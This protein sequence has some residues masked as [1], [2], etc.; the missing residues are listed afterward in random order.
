[1]P[2]QNAT[3]PRE[4]PAADPLSPVSPDDA[5][6]EWSRIAQQDLSAENGF[7]RE[8]KLRAYEF[9]FLPRE[10]HNF[11]LTEANSDRIASERDWLYARTRDDVWARRLADRASARAL[12]GA[13]AGHLEPMHYH[14]LVRAGRL[15]CVPTSEEAHAAGAGLGGMHAFL[16]SHGP[17]TVAGSDW[18]CAP[19]ARLQ[20]ADGPEARFALDGLPLSDEQLEGWLEPAAQ[21]HELAL[22]DPPAFGNAL[23]PLAPGA[24]PVVQ[25]FMIH[26]RDEEPRCAQA[27]IRVGRDEDGDPSR[28]ERFA[29]VDAF[30]EFWCLEELDAY[31]RIR[32]RATTPGSAR[33]FL[34]AVPCWEDMQAHLTA[35]MRLVPAVELAA[36]ELVVGAQDFA[37]VGIDAR[38]PYNRVV[39]ATPELSRFV[40]AKA[41]GRRGEMAAGVSG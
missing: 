34:G 10:A 40:I 24:S 39:P 21:V 15:F 14:I 5:A 41:R 18:S 30:G 33:P 31:G 3:L 26:P 38:P 12:F 4:I 23:S 11:R 36:F 9:G 27:L 37:V 16:T 7:T 6:G 22:I 35:L 28:H 1:M 17:A 32:R 20:A 8:Q 19:R 25:L 2:L 13:H 29:R